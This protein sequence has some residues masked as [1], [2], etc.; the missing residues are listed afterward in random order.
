MM[1]NLVTFAAIAG[2]MAVFMIGLAI[3]GASVESKKYRCQGLATGIVVGM[4]FLWIAHR[5]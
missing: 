4:L 5:L 1:D 2:P 3:A